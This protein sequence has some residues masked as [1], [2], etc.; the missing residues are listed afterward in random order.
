MLHH[1]PTRELQDR[2][3]SEVTRVL[4]PE[5]VFAGT[6]S[7]GTGALFKAIHI[8]DTLRPIDPDEL[9]ARL[10]RAGLAKPV[11]ETEGDS[12]RFRA[13]KPA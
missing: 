12:F 13:I 5:G 9:P 1:V 4:A 6:D 8:G 7:V 2:V 3:F 11:V 10:T